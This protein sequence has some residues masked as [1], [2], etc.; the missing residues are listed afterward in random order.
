M[1]VGGQAAPLGLVALGPVQRQ[2]HRLQRLRVVRR[3]REQ[4]PVQVRHLVAEQLVIQLVRPEALLDGAR[5]QAHLVEVSAAVGVVQP[6]QFGGVTA[7]DED[8]VAVIELPR[9]EQR[10]R[11]RELPDDVLRR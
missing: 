5:Q 9:P 4:V 11:V 3:A 1:R 6:A 10:H 2:P 7:G 8:A